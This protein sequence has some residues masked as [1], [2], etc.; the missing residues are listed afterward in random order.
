MLTVYLKQISKTAVEPVK[1]FILLKIYAINILNY[2]G[3]QKNFLSFI[4]TDLLWRSGVDK[5]SNDISEEIEYN[6]ESNWKE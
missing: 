3:T 2:F 1:N 6:L 5:T 4:T